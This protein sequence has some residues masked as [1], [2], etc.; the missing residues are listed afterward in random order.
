MPRR[1]SCRSSSAPRARHESH[2]RPVVAAAVVVAASVVTGSLVVASAAAAVL[3]Q[4]RSGDDRVL[5]CWSAAPSTDA[6]RFEVRI[7]AGDDPVAAC[8][9]A[10]DRRNVR[11]R[12]STSVAGVRDRRRDHGGRPR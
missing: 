10:V 5:A 7:D 3:W 2:A 11:D 4:S 12:R 1:C 6:N 8:A 9:G